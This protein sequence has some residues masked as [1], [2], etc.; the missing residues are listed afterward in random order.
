M[1]GHS[2]LAGPPFSVWRGMQGLVTVSSTGR[3]K[4][5]RERLAITHPLTLPQMGV[6]RHGCPD[7][8]PAFDRGTAITA[9]RLLLA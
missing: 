5:R 7:M 2:R 8:D 6:L 3:Q 4:V 9:P 1:P